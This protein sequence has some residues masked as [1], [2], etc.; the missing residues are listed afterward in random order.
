M[1]KSILVSLALSAGLLT[2]LGTVSTT[3]NAAKYHRGVPK[4]LIGKWR[5]KDP[6]T[7]GQYDFWIISKSKMDNFVADNKSGHDKFLG[8]Y[9]TNLKYKKVG[10]YYDTFGKP[11]LYKTENAEAE[12]PENAF[13]KKGNHLIGGFLMHGKF[14]DSY[15]MTK[16]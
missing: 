4:T 2:G 15:T 11:H 5:M 10:K 14:F 1:K 3:A 12:E 16:Y 13:Y 7:H 8:Q 9:E 6:I